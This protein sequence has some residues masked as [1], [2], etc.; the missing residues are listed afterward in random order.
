M[1]GMDMTRMMEA[2][3]KAAMGDDSEIKVMQAEQVAKSVTRNREQ[4]ELL[5][6]ECELML[7]RLLSVGQMRCV[8][9]CDTPVDTASNSMARAA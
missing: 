1:D 4:L 3:M 6:T 5:W 2:G 9:W 8:V 7:G